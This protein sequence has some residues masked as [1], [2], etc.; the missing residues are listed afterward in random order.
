MKQQIDRVLL[1]VLDSVGCGDAPDA[2]AYGDAGA[3][4]LGHVSQAVDG[5]TLPQLGQLGLG[6]LTDIVGVPP[7][8]TA[9]GSYGRLTE[10]S[11]GKDTT[12]GHWELAGVILAQPFPTYPQGFPAPLMAEYEARIGRGTL[13]NVPAS[14]TEILKELG[15][16]HM[17]TGKPI[18]YT[19]ADSVFQVAAHEAIIPV[20]ELYRFCEIARALLTGDHAVGRVIARPFLGEPGNFTRTERRKD[21]SLEP[22]T[23]TLLD[24]VKAAGQEVMGVGKIEDIFA[25]RGLTQSKHTG[26]N[27]AGVDAIVDFLQSDHRGLIFANLVDFDSLY[28]H[29]NDPPCYAAALEAFDRRL[30]AIMNSLQTGDVLII[31]ADH[32]NDP[33]MPS[34]DHSRER[35]PIL[36][37]GAPITPNAQLGTRAGFAD[38]TATIAA[39][40]HV[41]WSGPGDSFAPLM[42]TN[43][44]LALA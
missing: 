4:T 31:T 32:G 22:Q 8:V 1:I 7:T 30:P 17:R 5:L 41:P 44:Q 34:T 21:F 25:H 15:A 10:V 38:V 12:T 23:T 26:N 24:A 43:Q 33:T 13:G 18:I 37:Y 35:V 9:T 28:G 40:L 19:S 27:M 16:A 39:L 11:A 14:G 3:N 29:R 20:N 2:P 6:N 36:V 42:M